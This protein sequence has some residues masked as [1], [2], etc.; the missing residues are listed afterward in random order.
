METLKLLLMC[1]RWGSE[2]LELETFL[3]NVKADGY[4]GVDMWIP[5]EKNERNQ[6]RRLLQQYELKIVSQQYQA[7]GQNIR[8]FCHSF[9]YHLQLSAELD[10]ILINSHSGH[11]YFS[12]DD[13]LRVLDTAQ[14]FEE[15]FGYK[16]S[17]ETHRGRMLYS[18]GAAKQLFDLRPDFQITADFS[19][20]V[21][22]TES[23]LEP[24]HFGH[25]VEEAINRTR[26]IHARVGF[27]EGP[28]VPDPRLPNYSDALHHFICFWSKILENKVAQGMKSITVTPEFG[29]PPYMWTNLK[30][31]SPVASQWEI[32]LFIKQLFKKLVHLV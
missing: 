29:P 25:I 11:D 19:H 7:S 24:K 14:S 17:H 1:P 18:P 22:V 9:D 26:H 32:N 4:D 21:C 23:Y 12:L 3:H 6:L 28:Q 13:Q 31:N 2:H 30:D 16:V 15:R 10:P 5:F 8:E 27:P 20:W